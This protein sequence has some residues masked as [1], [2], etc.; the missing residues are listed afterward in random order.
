M[1]CGFRKH[2]K[3][4][5]SGG[6]T[7]SSSDGGGTPGG[8]A[9]G[10][11]KGP[12]P[13]SDAEQSRQAK[14]FWPPV[15][16][17]P[18]PR[19]EGPWGR[20]DPPHSPPNSPGRVRWLHHLDQNK[21]SLK[22]Q[23]QPKPAHG[24]AAGVGGLHPASRLGAGPDLTTGPSHFSPGEPDT[25]RRR[26]LLASAILSG[27]S[28]IPPSPQTRGTSKPAQAQHWEHLGANPC[29]PSGHICKPGFLHIELRFIT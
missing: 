10:S 29:W 11:Y 8:R 18:P 2:G 3:V 20:P 9:R 7:P 24:G 14:P 5:G 17:T 13:T 12:P 4:P 22:T 25:W 1:G 26:P 27:L 6:E 15:P 21:R 23:H 19:A 16:E 28:H